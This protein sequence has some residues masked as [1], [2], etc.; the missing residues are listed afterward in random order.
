MVRV[1]RLEVISLLRVLF[2]TRLVDRFTV[3]VPLCSQGDLYC[4]FGSLGV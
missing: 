1:V 3:V 4:G 2:A